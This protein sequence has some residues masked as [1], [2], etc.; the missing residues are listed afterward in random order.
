M[1]NSVV[2]ESSRINVMIENNSFDA[3][4]GQD[5]VALD[6]DPVGFHAPRVANKKERRPAKL[7]Q[8]SLTGAH[9]NRVVIK[10]HPGTTKA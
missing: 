3:I 10:S 6:G 1:D 2:E 9:N 4:Q 5:G 8:P 7:A